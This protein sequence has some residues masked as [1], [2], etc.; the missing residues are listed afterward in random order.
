[1]KEEIQMASEDLLFHGKLTVTGKRVLEYPVYK[2]VQ[3]RAGAW[4]VLCKMYGDSGTQPNEAACK[5]WVRKHI[6]HY[7][8]L[9]DY[10]ELEKENLALKER[11][12]QYE[13]EH[14]GD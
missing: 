14:T 7:I 1:V 5:E 8:T 10:Q 4:N 6:D 13:V 3:L 11:L 9:E 12:A 2:I